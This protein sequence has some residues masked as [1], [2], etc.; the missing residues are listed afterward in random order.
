VLLKNDGVLPLSKKAKRIHVAGRGANDLGRQCGGWTI[1]W[2]GQP[3]TPTVGTTILAAFEQNTVGP[4]RVTYSEDGTG[5]EG[6]DAVVVVASELPYAEGVG[7]RRDL[8]LDEEDQATL[9][10]AKKSG[11]PLVLVLLSGRPLILGEALEQADAVVAAWLPGTE[12]LG[13]TDVLL[14]DDAPTGKLPHSWPR[15]MAQVPINVGDEPYDPLFAFG[16]GLTY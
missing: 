10:N 6:A 11:V 16:F 3:G 13:I 2:Q 7:D 15:S 5:A 9:A 14:G 1:H 4:R 12:G 8:S